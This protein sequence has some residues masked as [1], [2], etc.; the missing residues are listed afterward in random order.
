MYP[1]LLVL[2]SFSRWLVLL[3]LTTALLRAYTALKKGH[4]FTG[5]DQRLLQA[6]LRIVQW[7]GLLGLG[8]YA[9]S[10]L[11][12]YFWSAGAIHEREIRFFGLEHITVMLV[13]V[14]LVTVG[15]SKARQR[16]RAAEKFNT[17]LRWWGWALLLMLSSIPWAFSPLISRPWLRCYSS[18]SMLP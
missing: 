4:R 15:A 18:F 3:S 7:Q 11:V 8:L 12:H 14:G 6:T 13:A 1:T 10:P 5:V 2:H 16:P 17:L 9:K